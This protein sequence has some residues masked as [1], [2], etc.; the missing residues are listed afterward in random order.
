MKYFALLAV[1]ISF[2]AFAEIKYACKGINGSEGY[3]LT[4]QSKSPT[5]VPEMFPVDYK[6]ILRKENTVYF[7]DMV[8]GRTQDVQLFLRGRRGSPVLSGTVY[9]DELYDV[10]LSINGKDFNFDCEAL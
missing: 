1:A 9:L 10:T 8:T 3:V 5:N 6:V 4:I 2:N 7:A